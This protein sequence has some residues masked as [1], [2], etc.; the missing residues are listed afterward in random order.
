MEHIAPYGVAPASGYT[1]VVAESGRLVAISGQ[2]AM[3]EAGQVVGLGD[4]RAQARQVFENLGRCLAAA[5]A[6]FDDVV[7][8]TYYLTDMSHLPAVRTVRD[9]YVDPT[10]PPASSAIQVS[11]LFQ[12]EFLLEVDAFA[13]I[14]EPPA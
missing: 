13:V 3:D 14:P 10:R 11:A 5:D 4:P 6:T 2:I 9:E 12:P 7:K 1:H 8:L